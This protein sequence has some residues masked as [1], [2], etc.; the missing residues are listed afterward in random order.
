VV[1]GH[2][3]DAVKEL[4]NGSMQYNTIYNG[5]AHSTFLPVKLSDNVKGY[6]H[7]LQFKL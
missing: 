2:V 7:N 6:E 4:V 5:R 3:D 1:G